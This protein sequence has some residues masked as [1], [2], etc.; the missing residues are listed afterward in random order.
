MSTTWNAQ[1]VITRRPCGRL[2]DLFFR[3]P[4]DANRG[5]P[6]RAMILGDSQ[7]TDVGGAGIHFAPSLAQAACIFYGNHP[8]TTFLKLGTARKN[9]GAYPGACA[10]QAGGG[11]QNITSDYL[12]PG[13]TDS[14]RDTLSS[15][16]NNFILQPDWF[17]VA[18]RLGIA[19]GD[20]WD[21]ANASILTDVFAL[22]RPSVSGQMTYYVIRQSLPEGTSGGSQ[23]DSGTTA[24]DLVSDTLS[25]KSQTIGPHTFSSSPYLRIQFDGSHASNPCRFA[26]VRFRNATDTRGMSFTFFSDGG[27][28]IRDAQIDHPNMGAF[29]RGLGFDFVIRPMGTNDAYSGSGYTA[30]EW[31]AQILA[32]AAWLRSEVFQDPTFPIIYLMDDYRLGGTAGQN[33][34]YDQYP[35]VIDEVELL[36][37][38]VAGVNLRRGTQR[39]GFGPSTLDLTGLTSKGEWAALTVYS[40][41]D[42][43]WIKIG[44]SGFYRHFK[45]IVAHTSSATDCPLASDTVAAQSWSEIRMGASSTQTPD[46]TSDA[47]HHSDH[48]GR[49]RGWAAFMG[50]L[51]AAGASNPGE[52][53]FASP[54]A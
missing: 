10:V 42:R 19:G 7:E 47:I 6:V 50:M 36:I 25:M 22:T 33:T 52:W 26:G 29:I 5:R 44:T 41:N 38:N 49:T 23:I 39:S 48:E 30:A 8:E 1:P 54:M 43:V 4:Y 15:H 13:V 16:T 14:G 28:M 2:W 37:G 17:S 12:P 34:Q 9:P 20:W 53:K 51:G 35:G 27:K 11:T 40:V 24:M 18:P 31:K 21:K 3:L 45:C 32:D 46:A